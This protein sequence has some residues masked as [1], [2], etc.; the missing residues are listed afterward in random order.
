[1]EEGEGRG[2]GGGGEGINDD[3]VGGNGGSTATTKMMMLLTRL[4]DTIC[5][6]LEEEG[7]NNYFCRQNFFQPMPK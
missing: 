6:S 1:M 3:R 2:V 7:I 4:R 5:N